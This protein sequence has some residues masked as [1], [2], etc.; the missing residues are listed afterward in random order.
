[1]SSTETASD[2]NGGQSQPPLVVDSDA[3][4]V[5]Q[6]PSRV[7]SSQEQDFYELGGMQERLR[8]NQQNLGWFGKFFGN[9]STA[10]TNLAGIVVVVCTLALVGTI[11]A[12]HVESRSEAQKILVGLLSSALAFIFG[13]S[14]RK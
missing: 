10:P 14:G 12:E 9:N 13:A 3:E 7:S 8:H 5:A 4:S 1:M 11:F 2:G 6:A